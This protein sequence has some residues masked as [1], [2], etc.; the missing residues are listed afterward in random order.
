[1]NRL[2]T[3]LLVA[4]ISTILNACAAPSPPLAV[5]P[6]VGPEAASHNLQGI[7]AY[8][9]ERWDEA[10]RHFEAAI[11]ASPRLAEP[12][13]NLAL[14]LH[15]LGEHQAATAQFKKA[16]ELD[17]NNDTIR[18]SPLFQQHVD[19]GSTFERHLRGGYSY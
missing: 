18:D 4:G 13:Y 1:M 17:P 19:E 14:T 11:A 15:Q 12:H 16:A 10:R 7:Q 9:Q 8:Q 3:C 2:V 5:L 6:T